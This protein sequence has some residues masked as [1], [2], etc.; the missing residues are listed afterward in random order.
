MLNSC[1]SPESSTTA[2]KARSVD[3]VI[4][5]SA[6]GSSFFPSGSA[7]TETSALPW[8]PLGVPPV[9]APW[10]RCHTL[11]I[12]CVDARSAFGTMF[13]SGTAPTPV[14]PWLRSSRIVGSRK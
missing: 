2:W 6:F 10:T 11:A 13:E 12:A 5:F 7:V 3:A 9:A 1:E 8:L 14:T 4:V